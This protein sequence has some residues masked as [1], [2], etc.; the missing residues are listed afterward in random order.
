MDFVPTL[1]LGLGQRW[2]AKFSLER[3]VWTRAGLPGE[4][5]WSKTG[6]VRFGQAVWVLEVFAETAD[7]SPGSGEDVSGN[8]VG[9]R[10]AGKCGPEVSVENGAGV[11]VLDGLYYLSSSRISFADGAG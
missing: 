1:Q 10:V 5:I 3:W 8:R 11:G 6:N 4:A 7:V 2:I 9:V